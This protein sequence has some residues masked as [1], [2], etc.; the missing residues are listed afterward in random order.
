[1]CIED[2]VTCVHVLK[3]V[4]TVKLELYRAVLRVNR[5][6]MYGSSIHQQAI[7]FRTQDCLNFP[8]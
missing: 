7:K 8:L 2:G 1:M 6:L 4:K 3:I 5:E